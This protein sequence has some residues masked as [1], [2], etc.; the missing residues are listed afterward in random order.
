MDVKEKREPKII[1]DGV[2]KK[3][4]NYVYRWKSRYCRFTDEGIFY[5][6]KR[7]TS[8]LKGKFLI[9]KTVIK[10]ITSD[11]NRM[12]LSYNGVEIDLRASSL[13][14]KTK[15]LQAFNQYEAK[16]LE[17]EEVLS[18]SSLK[19]PAPNFL[20]ESDSDQETPLS[21]GIPTIKRVLDDAKFRNVQVVMQDLKKSSLKQFLKQNSQRSVSPT[22]KNILET[23]VILQEKLM[24]HF[25]CLMGFIHKKTEGI[26]TMQN[27][28]LTIN[29]IN[30]HF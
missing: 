7:K 13:E 1:I 9:K 25:E 15:W 5:Y 17:K 6:G 8:K 11:P 19:G 22:L 23:F 30:V 26:N 24:N 14:N 4:T 27:T 3:W 16:N 20:V 2:L 21:K 10:S 28:L 29:S 12:V 18:D